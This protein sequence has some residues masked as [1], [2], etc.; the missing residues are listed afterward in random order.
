MLED[1]QDVGLKLPQHVMIELKVG[2]GA[3]SASHLVALEFSDAP[4]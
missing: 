1:R 3:R 4:T 2:S